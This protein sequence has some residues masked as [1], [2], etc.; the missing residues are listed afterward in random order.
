MNLVYKNVILTSVLLWIGKVY[1]QQA[2]VKGSVACL[3]S[4]S[5]L[6]KQTSYNVKEI[7]EDIRQGGDAYP[8]IQLL[9]WITKPVLQHHMVK[10]SP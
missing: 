7:L 2:P 1:C 4:N 10:P 5:P 3:C 6:S 9:S 8:G